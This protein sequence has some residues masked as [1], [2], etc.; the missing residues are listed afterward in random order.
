MGLAEGNYCL[1]ETDTPTNHSQVMEGRNKNF[2]NFSEVQA[3][4][5]WLGFSGMLTVETSGVVSAC[6]GA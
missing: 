1:A 6:L 4:I 5:T 2:R 3:F